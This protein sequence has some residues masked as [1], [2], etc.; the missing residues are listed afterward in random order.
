[1]TLRKNSRRALVALVQLSLIASAL[2]PA[3]TMPAMAQDG[4]QDSTPLIV[5]L[6]NDSPERVP[7]AKPDPKSIEG[8]IWADADKAEHQA[9]SSGERNSDPALDAYISSVEA[10]VACPFSGDIRA[11]VMDRPF[12]NADVNPNG[13]AEVWSGL[14]LR[15]QTEDQL[16]FVLGHETGHFRHS[17]S[18][19]RYHELKAGNDAFM[20]GSAVLLL[21]LAGAAA[22]SGGYGSNG[23]HDYNS[24]GSG[25]IDVGYLGTVAVLM[26]YSRESEAQADAYGLQYATQAGYFPGAGVQIWRGLLDEIAASDDP[27]VRKLGTRINIFGSHPLETDRI[28]ALNAEDRAAHGGQLS[29]RS[30][31][32]EKAARLA[33]RA[34]IRPFLGAWLKDDLRRKDYG[35]TLFLIGRLAQDGEDPGVLN[36]YKGEAYRERGRPD[37][38]QSALAAYQTAA[39]APDAPKE[40]PRQ[41]GDVYRRL[42]DNA[43]AVKAYQ[44]Y[45]TASPDAS[46]AWMVQDEVDTLNKNLSAGAPATA[47]P[48]QGE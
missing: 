40:T 12:F 7:G 13:Y 19:K 26:S 31:D 14:L 38:L 27:K 36:F 9:K 24:Y 29:A 44:A 28:D 8:G 4:A 2:A 46:D 17:H 32:D 35:E 18:L 43:S 39:Q 5:N 11:L 37:D 34:H 3:A 30:E 21:A 10:K 41:I 1:M 23:Y 16:A 20:V 45:L 25:L 22:N 15:A 48:S 6:K 33:Y 42:G 47:T